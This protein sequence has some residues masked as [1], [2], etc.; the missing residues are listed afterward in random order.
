ML[1]PSYL[2][3]FLRLAEKPIGK[4]LHAN[5]RK[6]WNKTLHMNIVMWLDRLYPTQPKQVD[7]FIGIQVILKLPI[8]NIFC[9]HTIKLFVA[10]VILTGGLPIQLVNIYNYTHADHDHFCS[11]TAIIVV[12]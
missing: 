8:R 9:S 1:C 11:P 2:T 6:A 5:N 3:L 10:I 12:S 7:H 4:V